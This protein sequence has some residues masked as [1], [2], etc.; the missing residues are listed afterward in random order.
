MNKKNKS[1]EL[2]IANK[3]IAF[4]KREKAKRAAELIILNLEIK[5][6]D[7]EKKKRAE[8]L[9][10]ANIE[11]VFQNEEKEKTSA[12]LINSETRYRRLFE[13]AKDG[14]LILDAETGMITDVNPYLIEML[15]YS[16]EQFVEKEIWEIGFF[17]DIV[18][19]HDKFIEL[20]Q[21]K[22]IRYDD[23]PLETYDGR[24]INVEF[25]SNIYLVNHR[26]VIQC[27]IR[28]ITERKQ[29]EN[30]LKAAKDYLDEIINSVASPIFV[31]DEN[32]KFCLVNDAFCSLINKI[33]E[34]LIGNTDD[35]YFPEEQ[36]KVFVA[37]DKEVF[38]T[39]KENINE[40]FLT[41]STGLIRTIVTR[42]TLYTDP[43]GNK[44][45]VGVINDITERQQKEKE[46]KKL[47][48][49]LE[50]KVVERTIEL[51]AANKELKAF[52]FSVSHDLRAPLRRI[53]GFAQILMD[54]HAGKLEEDGKKLCSV[55]MDN[56]LK[57]GFLIDDLLTFAQLS[58]TDISQSFINMKE[59]V[60]SVYKEINDVKTEQR[61][62]LNV[63]E[64]SDVRADE[65][66]IRQVWT[67][68]LSNAVKYTS[69]RE[70][71]MIS[72]TCEK[73]K[74]KCIYCVKDNGVGFDMQYAD[75]LFGVFQRL[76]S[77]QEFEGT[78]VGLAI[79]KR[80]VKRHGGNVWAE[81]EVNKGASFYFSLPNP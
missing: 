20:Q 14:I 47:N 6:Q 70:K 68:L 37:K 67:N 16:K 42:K 75:K 10:I 65:T 19:N 4:L 11:L 79:V 62:K 50:K 43:A 72:V 71:A 39:G 69:K 26:K 54:D 33:R 25:V 9:I 73:E 49:T 64:I 45:L 77:E 15:G 3:E 13:T 63:D 61:I 76:H 59:M 29:D 81:S 35:N 56:S 51:E 74:G 23:L 17:K 8:E 2:I 1:D 46:I 40:E 48:E 31:K 18:A 57:M 7:H 66:L 32:H 80:I 58:Q 78:G 22:Y 36:A 24:K 41:D 53:N 55:I 34:K 52:S 30:A 21:K 38:K 60:H 12:E 44:F 27:N 28:N 5:F